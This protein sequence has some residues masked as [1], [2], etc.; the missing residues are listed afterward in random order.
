M[1]ALKII[2]VEDSQIDVYLLEEACKRKGLMTDIIVFDD[3]D[4]A[5]QYFQKLIP[6]AAHFAPDVIIVDFYLPWRSGREVIQ[7]I[8]QKEILA[9]IPVVL[10]TSRSWDHD[11]QS[12]CHLDADYVRKTLDQTGYEEMADRLIAIASKKGLIVP[13]DLI[14]AEVEI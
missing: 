12:C 6:S 2:Y 13:G 4:K 11:V 14:S 5:V 7:E 3:G 8:R 1:G 10:F 9:S